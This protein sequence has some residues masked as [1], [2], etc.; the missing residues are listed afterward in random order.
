MKLLVVVVVELKVIEVYANEFIRQS[1]S[2]ASALRQVE[3][4]LI[5]PKDSL[6]ADASMVFYLQRCKHTVCI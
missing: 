3:K 5:F 4:D 6:L 2:P 1:M